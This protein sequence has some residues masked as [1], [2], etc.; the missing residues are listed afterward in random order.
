MGCCFSSSS[1]DKGSGG[2]TGLK[3]K[4]GQYKT[5]AWSTDFQESKW[6]EDTRNIWERELQHLSVHMDLPRLGHKIQVFV[7]GKQVELKM[8]DGDTK[9]KVVFEVLLAIADAAQEPEETIHFIRTRYDEFVKADGSGDTSQ[10][11]K[12]FLTEVVPH[13]SRLDHVLSLCHQK[14]VFPA[15]YSIKTKLQDHLE[16]KDKRGSWVLQL[17]FERGKCRVVHSKVQTAKPDFESGIEEFSFKWELTVVLSGLLLEYVEL[18]DVNVVGVDV[19]E[20]VGEGRAAEI[21]G[22]FNEHYQLAEAA[23]VEVDEEAG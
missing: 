2:G 10:Q 13:D 15:F 8:K 17:F 12:S 5:S 1:G 4:N 20:S 18:I 16:F 14:I 19:H 3:G 11:L 7:D 22:I 21:R 23:E 9:S 6:K